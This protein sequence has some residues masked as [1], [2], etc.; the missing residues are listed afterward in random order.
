MFY[1]FLRDL[2]LFPEHTWQVMGP[3]ELYIYPL[4]VLLIFVLSVMCALKPRPPLPR[5]VLWFSALLGNCLHLYLPLRD[6]LVSGLDHVGHV[7]IYLAG[8]RAL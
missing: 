1:W 5:F 2:T 3:V 6:H 7:A 8:G 4:A